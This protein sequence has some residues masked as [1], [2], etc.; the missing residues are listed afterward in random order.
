MSWALEMNSTSSAFRRRDYPL[1]TMF[2]PAV[3]RALIV[4]KNNGLGVTPPESQASEI[5]STSSA[6]RRQEYPLSPMFLR[7]IR[8]KKLYF[9]PVFEN[10]PL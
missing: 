5:R 7:C 10:F 9:L 8:A 3:A 6:F 4:V 1:S 2:W